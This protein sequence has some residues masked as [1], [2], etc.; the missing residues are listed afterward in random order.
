MSIKDKKESTWRLF[1]PDHVSLRASDLPVRNCLYIES[2]TSAINNL[3]QK[4]RRIRDPAVDNTCHGQGFFSPA[5]MF[6]NVVNGFHV[7]LARRWW[8]AASLA[9]QILRKIY[10][11]AWLAK[12]TLEKTLQPIPC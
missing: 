12:R 1:L 9:M 7:A 2:R 8:V 3:Q 6:Q 10:C 11:Q 4:W 5:R